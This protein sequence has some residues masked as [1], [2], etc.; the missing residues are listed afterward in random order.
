MAMLCTRQPDYDE[1]TGETGSVALGSV[2]TSSSMCCCHLFCSTPPLPPSLALSPPGFTLPVVNRFFQT[3][4]KNFQ[5]VEWHLSSGRRG[6]Q[7]LLQFGKL[8]KDLFA[9]DFAA[10]LCAKTA[11][12]IAL[13]ATEAKYLNSNA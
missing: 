8:D 9:L 5:L 10:P 2:R 7:T 13:A 3:S 6:S 4:I 1:G 12:A 11:F